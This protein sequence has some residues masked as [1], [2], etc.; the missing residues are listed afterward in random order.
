MQ[1]YTVHMVTFLVQLI[2]LLMSVSQQ[3]IIDSQQVMS[4]QVMDTTAFAH[5]E[6][7]IYIYLFALFIYS[8]FF[9]L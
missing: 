1:L 2:L 9:G 4:V 5:C 3:V 6:K 8:E 7:L